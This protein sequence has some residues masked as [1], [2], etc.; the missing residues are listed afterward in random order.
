MATANSLSNA[1]VAPPYVQE[2]NLRIVPMKDFKQLTVPN[3][4]EYMPS[5]ICF[6]KQATVSNFYLYPLPSQPGAIHATIVRSVKDVTQ[7]SDVIDLPIEWQDVLLYALAV[8]LGQVYG[9]HLDDQVGVQ[10]IQNQANELLNRARSFD[11]PD[12]VFLRPE[13]RSLGHRGYW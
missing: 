2:Y 5:M 13:R 6:D 9:T 4:V 7:P 3:T 8:R 12:A 10:M 1:A 11:R